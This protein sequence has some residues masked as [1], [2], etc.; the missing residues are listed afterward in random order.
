M[1]G[2]WT[3]NKNIKHSVQLLQ[4]DKRHRQCL[5][6][7]PYFG[8]QKEIAHHGSSKHRQ[9]LPY[10][11]S[12]S[13]PSCSFLPIFHAVSVVHKQNT[14]IRCGQGCSPN[15]HKDTMYFGP[16]TVPK[17]YTFVSV[18]RTAGFQGQDRNAIDH[19]PHTVLVNAKNG[20]VVCI[21]EELQFG[22]FQ[23]KTRDAGIMYEPLTQR[24]EV[25]CE[26]EGRHWTS[27]P[28]L[29]ANFHISTT[30]LVHDDVCYT[31]RVYHV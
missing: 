19:H 25:N 16:L 8:D 23:R 26:K 3:P 7:I 5:Q 14:E 10:W 6:N 31:M 20:Y 1:F 13:N 18:Y 15:V 29:R 4:V 27:L 28:Y 22:G 24:F 21:S 12:R 11:C 30:A 17:T 2:A 9:L